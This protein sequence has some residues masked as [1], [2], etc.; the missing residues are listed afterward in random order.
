MDSKRVSAL[1][2]SV[3]LAATVMGVDFLRPV[4]NC[5]RKTSLSMPFMPAKVFIMP[6]GYLK[7]VGLKRYLTWRP[8]L[9]SQS[10]M[11]FASRRKRGRP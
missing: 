11:L 10:M 3:G 5:S 6:R 4:W 2:K 8:P 7:A 1:L 9:K